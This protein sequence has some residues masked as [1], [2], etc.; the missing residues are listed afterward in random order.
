MDTE[1]LKKLA[2][3]ELK[4]LIITAARELTGREDELDARLIEP[5]V[6]GSLAF[7]HEVL[8]SSYRTNQITSAARWG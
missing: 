5:A 6:A 3:H 8:A 4:D 2:A 7:A 1:D